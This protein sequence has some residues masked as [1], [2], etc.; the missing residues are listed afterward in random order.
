MPKRA[1][2]EETAQTKQTKKHGRINLE[3]FREERKARNAQRGGGYGQTSQRTGP[4]GQCGPQGQHGRGMMTSWEQQ[5]HPSQNV[6]DQIKAIADETNAPELRMTSLTTL[7]QSLDELQRNDPVM[8]EKKMP[9]KK[10]SKWKKGTKTRKPGNGTFT[11]NFLLYMTPE[12]KEKQ[13]KTMPRTMLGAPP[14]K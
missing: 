13:T 11:R 14:K 2:C 10:K 6:R 12:Q 5:G 7:K 9:P 4:Q 1:A 3:K 8:E